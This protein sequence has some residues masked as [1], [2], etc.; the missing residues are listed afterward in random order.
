MAPRAPSLGQIFLIGWFLIHKHKTLFR[1]SLAF[2]AIPKICEN[3]DMQKR[4]PESGCERYFF[5]RQRVESANNGLL[6][7]IDKTAVVYFKTYKT[8]L[9]LFPHRRKYSVHGN[10]RNELTLDFSGPY[11]YLGK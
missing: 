5:F 8:L 3:A 11:H 9:R 4:N 1:Y 10:L 7:F 2:M 6:I